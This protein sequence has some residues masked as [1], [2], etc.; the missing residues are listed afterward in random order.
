MNM[1]LFGPDLIQKMPT[2]LGK[3]LLQPCLFATDEAAAHAGNWGTHCLWAAEADMFPSS[4]GS[5][6]LYESLFPPAFLSFAPRV[7][8]IGAWQGSAGMIWPPAICFGVLFGSFLQTAFDMGM[9][10]GERFAEN[11][12][13]SAPTRVT[14]TAHTIVTS[15]CLSPLELAACVAA[16]GSPLNTQLLEV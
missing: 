2:L 1:A 8:V 6:R 9:T 12:L 5:R 4:A 15:L 13:F 11:V 14:L 3:T 10:P 16:T 7:G